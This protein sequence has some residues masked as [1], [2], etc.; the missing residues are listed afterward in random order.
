MECP[1]QRNRT[2]AAGVVAP[3]AHPET[4]VHPDSFAVLIPI[5][6]IVL[7]IGPLSAL[8]FSYTPIG[9]AFVKRL[10]GT[11][12]ASPDDRLLELHDEIEGLRER[13]THQ[14][15]RFEELHDR[16][17]FAERLLARG[18]QAVPEPE[19]EATPV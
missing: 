2:N 12:K 5:I 7:V 6:S 3:N 14:D 18:S 16:L 11:G 9:R 13:L 8:A 15:G 1:H 10:N 4:R 17:D 19:R